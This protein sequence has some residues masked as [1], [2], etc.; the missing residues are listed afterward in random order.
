MAPPNHVKISPNEGSILLAMSAFTSSQC[1][2]ISAAAKTYNVSKTILF[3]RIQGKASREDFTLANRRITVIEEEII[4]R[5]ILKLDAQGLLPTISLV[6]AM[7]DT[8]YKARNI[9]PIGVNW[10]SSFIK[11]TP[12]LEIKLRRIYKYQR[13]LYRDRNI[14]SS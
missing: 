5:D 7:A 14:F 9:S 1:A 8:I 13:K 3:Q 4:V 12:A 6:R 11:R 2:S 10:A